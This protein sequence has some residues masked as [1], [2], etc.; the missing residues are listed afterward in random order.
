MPDPDLEIR[1]RGGGGGAG[2]EAVIQTLRASVWSKNKGTGEGPPLASPGLPWIRHC[3]QHCYSLFRMAFSIPF[4]S[5]PRAYKLQAVYGMG[6][7]Q[8]LW[9]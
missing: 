5:G 6:I 8:C 1:G 2:G 3:D 4:L 9:S 7:H